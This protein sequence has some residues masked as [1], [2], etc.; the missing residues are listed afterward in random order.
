[1]MT[2]NNVASMQYAESMLRSIDEINEIVM[3]SISAADKK[4]DLKVMQ[5]NIK[6]FEKE[7]HEEDNNVTETGERELV[8]SIRLKFKDYKLSI[9][10]QLLGKMSNY[11]K[12]QR[13][14]YNSIKSDIFNISQLNMNAILR[15][16]EQVSSS[17]KF[18]YVWLSIIATIF[19]LVSF[20]FIFNF[21]NYIADPIEDF[22]NTIKRFSKNKYH[23]RLNYKSKDEFGELADAFNTLAD[24]L[25]KFES[26]SKTVEIKNKR[27]SKKKK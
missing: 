10:P 27:I 16:N 26:G 22:T 17:V 13:P 8:D 19:L 12:N 6:L 20:S 15:K 9:S 14:L 25:D 1:M 21:P 2:K 5:L 23:P 7:L 24:Q 11:T 18:Y 4:I 3:I